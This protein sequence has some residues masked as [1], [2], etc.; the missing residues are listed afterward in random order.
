MTSPNPY[1]APQVSLEA[2]LAE[3]RGLRW[4]LFSFDGRIRRRTFW[5]TNLAVAG[6]IYAL[7]FAFALLAYLAFDEQQ[8]SMVGGLVMGVVFVV[9]VPLLWVSLALQVKR[10]HDRGK[11]GAWV[12]INFVP[13]IGPLWALAELGFLR[14]TEGPNQ[15]GPEPTG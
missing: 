4:L 2:P 6:G 14:G 9:Y 13:L 11:G 5:L 1:A 10:W 12:F 15:F 7:V 8:A 3:Q